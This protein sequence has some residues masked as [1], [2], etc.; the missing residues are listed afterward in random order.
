MSIKAKETCG[1]GN[2][3]LIADLL[4]EASE[5]GVFRLV[6]KAST[7]YAVSP[8]RWAVKQSFISPILVAHK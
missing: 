6:I 1:C 5:D 3:G 8:S 2:G 7:C 4:H